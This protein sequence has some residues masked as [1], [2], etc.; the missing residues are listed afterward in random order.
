MLP[1]ITYRCFPK[2]LSLSCDAPRKG[3]VF[4][5]EIAYPGW[6]ARIDGA[7]VP[8]ITADYLLRAVVV[9]KGKHTIDFVYKPRMF[10]AALFAS[11]AVFLLTTVLGV[12]AA[13]R[14]TGKK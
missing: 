8:V 7:R 13:V 11:V 12:F 4:L 6:Q 10:R 2:G 9:E 5:S 3:I 14:K 1:Q